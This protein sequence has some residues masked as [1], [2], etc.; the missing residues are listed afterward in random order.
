MT[1]A[2]LLKE[3]KKEH[4]LAGVYLKLYTETGNDIFMTESNQ[5]KFKS[6]QLFDE[7]KE[8]KE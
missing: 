5:H 1:K 6:L 8:V 4:Q 7:A 3:S 2:E